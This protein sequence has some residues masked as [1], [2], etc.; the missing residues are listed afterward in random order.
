MKPDRNLCRWNSGPGRLPRVGRPVPGRAFGASGVSLFEVLVAYGVLAVAILALLG[1]VPAAASQHSDTHDSTQALYLAEERMEQLLQ[2][3]QR[4]STL[5]QS[6]YPL[7]DLTLNRQW[8]GSPVPQETD[9]QMVH[10]QVTW[11]DQGRARRVLLQSYL[12]P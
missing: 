3:D 5:P 7:G 4:I 2:L 6:D 11:V 10:V 9:V 8:W 1:M 12:L